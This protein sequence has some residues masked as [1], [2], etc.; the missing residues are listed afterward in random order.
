MRISYDPG[1]RERTLEER[2]LDF[3]DTAEVFAGVTF[4]VTGEA[5]VAAD[6]G[7]GALDDPALG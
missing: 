5:A 7:K 1:K 4:E 2:G 3:D 6:P